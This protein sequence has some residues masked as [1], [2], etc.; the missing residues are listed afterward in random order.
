VSAGLRRSAPDPAAAPGVLDGTRSRNGRSGLGRRIPR[1]VRPARVT[2]GLGRAPG[3]LAIAALLL[4]AAVGVK[5]TIA[6]RTTPAPVSRPLAAGVHDITE[7]GFAQAFARA[8]LSWDARQPDQHQRQ[9][10]AFISAALD[11]NGGLQMPPRGQQQ[12]L[13]TAAIQDQPDAHGDRSITVAA[14]TTRQLLYLAVPV[15]RTTRGFLVVPR[16][17]ALVGPPV[18]DPG[19]APAE[20]HDVSDGALRAVAE[21][22]VTNYLAGQRTNLLADLDPAAI[23]SLP[24]TVLDV[25]SV[26]SITKA[27]ANR[28][29]VEVVADDGAGSQWTLRYELAVVRRDRW[30]VRAIEPD[31]VAAGGRP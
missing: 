6:P 15:H 16:Y 28:V 21:R 12:V 27:A 22:A 10:A 5:A 2:H 18:S 1:T 20:E 17:P 11:G 24:T 8:Y 7:Q 4:L 13:W 23:V 30:Y 14:Q 19:A 9:V 3:T 29:A 31:P 25:R 26:R